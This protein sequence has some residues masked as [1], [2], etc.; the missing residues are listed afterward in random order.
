MFF[1]VKADLHRPEP[2]AV[3]GDAVRQRGENMARQRG[4]SY[5]VETRQVLFTGG[6]W[7]FGFMVFF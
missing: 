7:S 1:F 3:T 2:L 5:L 4:D 6:K